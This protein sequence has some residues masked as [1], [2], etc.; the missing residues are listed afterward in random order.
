MATGVAQEMAKRQKK[1]KKKVADTHYPII[2][3]SFLESERTEGDRVG[4][5]TA[6]YWQ[7]EA[8]WVP[9]LHLSEVVFS[10]WGTLHLGCS[11][12]Y[13][14]QINSLLWSTIPRAQKTE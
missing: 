14:R 10:R 4:I 6:L 12:A 9:G 3:Q 8:G 5:T 2:P 13:V 11:K 1:K 7:Q